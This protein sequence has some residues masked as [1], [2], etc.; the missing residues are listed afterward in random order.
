MNSN[1]QIIRDGSFR[2]VSTN[3]V[4]GST[5]VFS[6]PIPSATINV[7]VTP[8]GMAIT[9]SGGLLFVANNNNY[10]IIGQDSISV[11]NAFTTLPET[12]IFDDSFN[13]P[14]TI[15]INGAGTKAYV[16]NSAD[17]TVTVIN[18]SSFVV[19]MVISGFDGP[20]GFVISE[21]RRR[22]YVNNYGA[23]P[24][25]G[26]GNG[27]TVSVVDL[28]TNTI[29]GSPIIVGLAPATLAITVDEKYVYTGNYTTGDNNSGTIS[30]I[31]VSNNTVSSTIGPF[32][33]GFS[34]IFAIAINQ[35]GSKAY[36][37]N[38]GSNNFAPFGT[39]VAVVDLNAEVI[40]KFIHVGI[41]PAGLALS[42][43][44]MF[45]YVTNYNTL[46]AGDGF[47]NLTAGQGTL[48]IISLSTNRPIRPTIPVGQSPACIV[49]SPDSKVAYVSNFISNTI[50]VVDVFKFPLK[51]G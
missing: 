44:G 50:S 7:G 22:A 4:N 48:N 20:S 46:Y 39:T 45:A 1:F 40:T 47:T 24:G 34:G 15:T 38:F 11:I 13:Q 32:S 16:T 29:I 27:N 25:V 8:C 5:E 35:S 14:Y 37:T 49:L 3:F 10:A 9:P 12:T 23:T 6:P 51:Y 21:S 18:I 31:N 26:S 17:L 2:N 19:S 36:V 43:D 30:K 41:Q 33:P 42:K 28:V